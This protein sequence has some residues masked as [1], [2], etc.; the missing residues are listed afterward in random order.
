VDEGVWAV[1]FKQDI[2]LSKA[3]RTPN[4]AGRES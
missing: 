1:A 3:M 2:F 4:A